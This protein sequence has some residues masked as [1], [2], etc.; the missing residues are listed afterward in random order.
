MSNEPDLASLR[1]SIERIDRELL[2]L[3]KE[4][5]EVVE[6]VARAKLATAVPFRDP[7]REEQVLQRVRHTA[8][9]LKLDTH[10]V[11][12]LYRLIMEMAISRQQAFVHSLDKA[13]LRVAYQGT[14]G[15]YSHLAAQQRYA[16]RPGGVLLKGYE[17]VR[18]TGDAVRSGEVDCALLPIENT[19]AGSMNE[20]YD[21]LAEGGLTLTGEVI[22]VTQHRLLGIKGAK[23]EGVRTIVS[24]PQALL[25]CAA[26]LQA[27]SDVRLETEPDTATAARRVRE[28][29][30]PTC[31][32][33]AS[34]NAAGVF[35]LEVLADQL[36][37]GQ[38]QFTRYVEVAV[39][40]SPVPE[41]SACKTSLLVVL[42]HRP[43]ALGEV[44]MRFARHS[45]NLS[46]LESRPLLGSNWKYQFYLDVEGHAAS[47]EMAEALEDIRPMT[48]RLRVLG[49]YPKA[50]EEPG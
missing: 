3:L 25:Q 12:R 32:A 36:H 29:N 46:K 9:A 10:E 26:Y 40:A 6:G 23:L 39:E 42:E 24:H 19:T 47:R 2:T 41:G 15:S 18:Q 30:D 50:P 45:V 8:A 14:E 20:T 11:E 38:D 4:R 1:A 13:P 22:R 16:L 49:T 33:I 34:E 37:A 21:L 35:G 27:L 31:A 43:G 48:S 44:L 17:T 7:S 28:R 5:M